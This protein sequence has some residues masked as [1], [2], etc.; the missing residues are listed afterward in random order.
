MI[1]DPE[2]EVEGAPGREAE[3]GGGRSSVLPFGSLVSPS[4]DEVRLLFSSSC[5][6]PPA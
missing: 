5:S 4:G 3:A 1:G 2:M 6:A